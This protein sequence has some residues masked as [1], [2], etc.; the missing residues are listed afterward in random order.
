MLDWVDSA[1]RTWGIAKAKLDGV[2]RN[3]IRTNDGLIPCGPAR[4][5]IGRFGE[6]CHVGKGKDETRLVEPMEGLVG[7]A[8]AV[9]VG[10]QRAIISGELSESNYEHLYVHYVIRP[11]NN[12]K[13]KYFKVKRHE[14]YTALHSLHIRL[15]SWIQ[16]RA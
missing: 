2:S 7:D 9:S 6:G 14:Y 3:R 16:L 5:F 12:M 10:L 11:K 1:L 8:L 15:A 13:F 4:S